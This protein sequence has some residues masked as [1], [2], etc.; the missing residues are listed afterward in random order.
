MSTEKSTEQILREAQDAHERLRDGLFYMDA[1]KK[2][3]EIGSAKARIK[4]NEIGMYKSD[5][6][7][8]EFEG[9]YRGLENAEADLY[10]IMNDL[11]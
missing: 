7:S 10:M 6:E 2:A 5:F 9:F 4:Y 3:E 8:E 11:H 1:L